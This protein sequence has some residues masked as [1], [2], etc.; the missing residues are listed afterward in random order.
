MGDKAGPVAGPICLRRRLAPMIPALRLSRARP[1]T[2]G[3]V[4]K[5][6]QGWRFARCSR[7]SY[8]SPRSV[9]TMPILERFVFLVARRLALDAVPVGGVYQTGRQSQRRRRPSSGRGRR[10]LGKPRDS[11]AG[12]ERRRRGLSTWG[13]RP[14]CRCAA[15]RP[16]LPSGTGRRSRAADRADRVELVATTPSVNGTSR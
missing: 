13:P 11:A 6:G 10:P 1:V 12:L 8:C 14:A 4:R 16:S 2:A 5:R 3:S 9:A 15:P 7:R